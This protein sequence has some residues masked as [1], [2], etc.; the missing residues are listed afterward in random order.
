MGDRSNFGIKQ[1]NG[2]TLYVYKHWGG[3]MMLNQFA[4]ALR[5][6]RNNGR[7]NDDTYGTRII[8]DELTSDCDRYLGAGF[9]INEITDNEH[10][11]PVFDFLSQTVTLYDENM[12]NQK[13]SMSVDGFI[14]KYGD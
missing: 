2:N 7:L 1:C 11:V 5:V 8:C 13:F 3:Y 6:V 9:S 14:D 4:N 10:S 12:K